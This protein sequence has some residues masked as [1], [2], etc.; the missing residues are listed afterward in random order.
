[1][2]H[3]TFLEPHL[4]LVAEVAKEGQEHGAAQSGDED[5]DEKDAVDLAHLEDLLLDLDDGCLAC[6]QAIGAR[7][8]GLR[9]KR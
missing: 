8:G 2:S 3:L 9:E 4:L 5:H 6:I 7:A 1:M